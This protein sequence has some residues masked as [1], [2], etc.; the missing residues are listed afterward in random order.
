MKRSNKVKRSSTKRSNKLKRS[1]KVKRNNTKR[2]HTGGGM[3][4]FFRGIM[5]LGRSLTSFPYKFLNTWNGR[6][7]PIN[8]NPY[9]VNQS[10]GKNNNMLLDVGYK[11]KPKEVQSMASDK[12]FS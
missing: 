9:A 5:N 11:L 8:L 4:S 2:K 12:T 6:V 7:Q 1:N 3:S 10:I